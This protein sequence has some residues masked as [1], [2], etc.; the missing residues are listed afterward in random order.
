MMDVDYKDIAQRIANKLE[1]NDGSRG[2]KTGYIVGFENA[3]DA[4]RFRPS[5]IKT[6]KEDIHL[7]NSFWSGIFPASSGLM[8]YKSYYKEG[9]EDGYIFYL[10]AVKSYFEGKKAGE[11]NGKTT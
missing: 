1:N 8:T 6:S 7:Y 2:Y 11:K 4:K 9:Y 3:A 5:D 10:E